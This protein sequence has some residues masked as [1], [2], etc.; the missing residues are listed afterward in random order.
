MKNLLIGNEIIKVNTGSFFAGDAVQIKGN[1]HSNIDFIIHNFLL[2]LN[3]P[4]KEEIATITIP[5][6]LTEN[7]MDFTGLILA[8]HIRLTKELKFQ[9][10]PLII[11][12]SLEFETILKMTSWANIL[13]TPN[14]Y[15]FNISN[16]G[17]DKIEQFITRIIKEPKNFS[18]DNFLERIDIKPPSN[19]QQSHHSVANDWALSRYFS[20]LVADEENEDYSLLKKKIEELDYTKTLHFKYLNAKGD[21]QKF[22]P[23]KHLYTPFPKNINGLR[24]GIIDDEI[25]KG[26]GAFYTYILGKAGAKLELFEFR[27]DEVKSEMLKRLE[28]WVQKNNESD[29]PI[30]LYIVDLRLHDSDFDEK[31]FKNISGNQIITFIKKLNKGIQVVVSTASNKVWNFQANLEQGVDSFIVK[32]DPETFSTSEETKLNL[33]NFC[34]EIERASDKVFLASLKRTIRLIKENQDIDKKEVA[35]IDTIFG[36]GGILDKIFELLILNCYNKAVLNQCLLL[37]FQIL[38]NY[39]DLSSIGDFGY[40]NKGK[41]KLASGSIWKKDKSRLDIFTNIPDKKISSYFLLVFGKFGFQ[42]EESDDT[43]IGYTVFENQKLESAYKSG[44]ETTFLVKMISVLHF[45]E[46]IEQKAIKQLIK[47]RYYR[48]NVAA[49]LTG[50]VKSSY[51]I[52]AKEDIMFFFNILKRVLTNKPN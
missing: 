27:K 5:I 50:T 39:L 38:E 26:W 12:S 7:F 16:S 14:V 41:T 52:S 36:S 24:I 23:K 45:R 28:K 31:D 15:Y 9:R 17:F 4:E 43:P 35:F 13:L 37:C 29:S 51:S 3:K 34:K 32:E 47:L 6:T 33:S 20:M 18:F 19:Y 48:S 8:H 2:E 11:Y 49:H 44:L 42:N 21:R 22:N 10:V 30:D 40:S 25:A 46:G 1:Y